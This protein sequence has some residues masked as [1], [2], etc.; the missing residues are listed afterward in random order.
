MEYRLAAVET[1]MAV[2]KAIV[3]RIET[4]IINHVQ[5][6]KDSRRQ[7]NERIDVAIDKIDELAKHIDRRENQMAGASWGLKGLIAGIALLA[8]A[9]GSKLAAI[10]SAL[11]R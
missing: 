1:D 5:E 6:T 11:L 9:A 4:A 3:P 2:M 7:T 10:G 8:G